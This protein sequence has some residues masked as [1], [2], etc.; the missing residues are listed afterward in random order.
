M[1]NILA[2]KVAFVTGAGKF[3]G[4]GAATAGKLASLGAL[5]VVTDVCR[6]RPELGWGNLS[7]G[8]DPEDLERIAQ[9]IRDAGGQAHAMA[10]DVTDSARVEEAIALTVERFGSIDILINN[11]GTV[12]GAAPFLDL[13]DDKWTLSY[14]VN[15]MGMVRTCRAAIP[16]MLGQGGGVIVNNASLLGIT[17]V[18]GYG[19]YT[20]TKHAVIGLTK[21]LA[22]E[23]GSGG[24][25]CNAICPGMI[26]TQ[27]GIVE[28]Q[29]MAAEHGVSVEE[30]ERMMAEP[31][32]LRRCGQPEEVAELM[33]FL[34]SPASSFLT[35]IAVPVSGGYPMGL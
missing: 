25:R 21:T 23:F 26:Q 7:V 12:A 18:A 6:S 30:A 29:M 31:A 28:A 4:M 19:A 13:S 22:A 35:G 5:V 16:H 27:M 8:E 32:A 33:A 2:D 24:I 9:S 11:A 1:G 20:A 14:D 17:A 10:V 34:A 15:L 3:R